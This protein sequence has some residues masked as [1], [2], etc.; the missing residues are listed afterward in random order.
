MIEVSTEEILA[1]LLDSPVYGILYDVTIKKNLIGGQY[2]KNRYG[3][4]TTRW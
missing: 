3:I 2:E 4:Q 1:I